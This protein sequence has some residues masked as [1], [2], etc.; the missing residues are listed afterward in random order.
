MKANRIIKKNVFFTLLIFLVFLSCN[1]ANKYSFPD[2]N[3]KIAGLKLSEAQMQLANIKV[4]EVREGN[5]GNQLTLTGVL[6]I[7]EQ[8]SVNVS[9]RISGRII[10]LN[11]KNT[12]EKIDKGDPL[13]EIF[14]DDLWNAQREYVSL[15]KNNWNFSGRYGPS[16]TLESKLQL[17]GLLPSQIEDLKKNEKIFYTTTIYSTVSGVIRTLNITEGQYVNKGQLLYSL[18]DGDKLWVEAQ[19]YPNE[20]HS[21]NIGTPIEVI[22]PVAGTLYFDKRINFINPAFETGKNVRIVRTSIDNPDKKLYPGMLALIA[23][24]TETSRGV[25][26][27]A[28]AVL[29]DQTGSTVWIQKSDG[30]FV[31]RK[32]FTG[33]H[34]RDSILITSGLSPLEKIVV[35]GVYLLN[36]EMILTKGYDGKDL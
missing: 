3:I 13:Y 36:S 1:H 24:R 10:K 8:S 35:S 4:A 25:V 18:A 28:E 22:V 9:S 6:K 2:E 29:E 12:G 30:S 20:I 31:S 32:V 14:S 7:D 15:Q 19:V 5:L 16:L 27:P 26:V 21:L 34:S 33:I 23:V 11:H 17:M